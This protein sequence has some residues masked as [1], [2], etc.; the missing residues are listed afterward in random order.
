MITPTLVLRRVTEDINSW[1]CRYRTKVVLFDL[2]ILSLF[3]KNEGQPPL[4]QRW[5]KITAISTY[6]L[7]KVHHSKLVDPST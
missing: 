5:L 3:C 7:C 1:S 2:E 6:G 4:L